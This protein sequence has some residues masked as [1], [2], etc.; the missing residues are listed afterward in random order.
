MRMTS[1]ASPWLAALLG[2]AT[3][4]ATFAAIADDAPAPPEPEPEPGQLLVASAAI[5]DP[6]F[7]HSVILL[8]RHDERGAFGIII[9]HP[10]DQRS[11]ATLMAR[12][13]GADHEDKTLEGTI[14]LN[15]GGPV[16]PQ[17]CFLVHTADY[18]RPGTVA[19]TN[20]IGVTPDCAVMR[21]IGHHQGPEKYLFTVGYTGWG[22]GQL[23]AEI[24]R[25]DWFTAPAELD[26][27]FDDERST[28][29]K[30]AL[31][32]RTRDL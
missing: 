13:E 19:V 11:I 15:L 5:Q 1:K 26:L 30:R 28:V 2:I 22:A 24:E 7:Y 18:N 14:R 8:V 31:D 9:N 20:H 10:L 12:A 21:D 23:E 6:R 27:L 3:I 4:F 32:R 16:Q 29:W 17:L 25:H